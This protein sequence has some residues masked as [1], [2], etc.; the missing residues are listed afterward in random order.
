[1]IEQSSLGGALRNSL[2]L[3]PAVETLHI[4]GFAILVG[5]IVTFDL[6]VIAAR[7]GLALGPWQSAVLPVARAGFAL[8]LPMGLLLFVA[9]ATAYLANPAFRLKLVMLALALGNV[10]AFHLMAADRDEPS[11]ALRL[12]AGLSLAAW[13]CVLSLGR[14]IAYV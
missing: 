6:R 3:Y 14:L 1:M 8:A 12:I 5:A 11:T 13:L 10:G 2:W 4:I 7:P 9:N